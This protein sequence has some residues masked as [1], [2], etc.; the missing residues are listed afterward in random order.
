MWSVGCVLLQPGAVEAHQILG[1]R[2]PMVDSRLG[3]VYGSI[4]DDVHS[5]LHDLHLDDYARRQTDREFFCYTFIK[6]DS[7]CRVV[8]T[9]KLTSL[10]F[11]SAENQDAHSD[12]WRRGNAT[13][14]NGPLGRWADAAV[15]QLL[16]SCQIE[17]SL[18]KVIKG[19]SR[20]CIFLLLKSHRLIAQQQRRGP[21]IAPRTNYS[22]YNIYV[23]R[24]RTWALE[25]V[26]IASNIEYPKGLKKGQ[27]SRSRRRTKKCKQ[28]EAISIVN[29]IE[30]FILRESK[31]WTTKKNAP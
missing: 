24:S 1:L 13:K 23:T 31:S 19:S 29:L 22:N 8:S 6:T 5:R 9:P 21:E 18:S 2:I 3:L 25:N 20:R 10:P 11:Y 28:L 7:S 15:V 30:I 27:R 4:I 26:K 17:F 14:K 12:R 16:L